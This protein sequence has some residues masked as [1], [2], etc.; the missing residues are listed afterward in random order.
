MTIS[1]KLLWYVS[2]DE[3]QPIYNKLQKSFPDLPDDSRVIDSTSKLH[4]HSSYESHGLQASLIKVN[5]QY[6][7]AARGTSGAGDAKQDFDLT[8]PDATRKSLNLRIFSNL[9]KKCIGS[10]QV[11]THKKRPI[12]VIRLELR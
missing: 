6:V 10:I 2:Q 5:G 9:L 11:L 3:Y 4:T 1:D 12:Q 7:V 8:D